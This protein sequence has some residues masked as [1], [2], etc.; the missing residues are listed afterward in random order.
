MGLKNACIEINKSRFNQA[1]TQ[2]K[3]SGIFKIK[4][5]KQSKNFTNYTQNNQKINQ[6]QPL[7]KK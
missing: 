2:E 4:S 6:N 1:K 7:L 5:Q 3:N